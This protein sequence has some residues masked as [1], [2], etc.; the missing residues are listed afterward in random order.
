MQIEHIGSTAVPGLA[1]KPIIDIMVGLENFA[2]A[3]SLVPRVTTLG[4]EYVQKYEA[5]MPLRRYFRRDTNGA[6]SHHLHMVAVGGEF[7]ERHLLFRDYL[8]QH[9]DV[10][11]DYA[12]LKRQLAAREWHDVN[13]YADA[14]TE[15]I[16]SIEERARK[17]R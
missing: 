9:P 16:R 7:W 5:V 1:A 2:L 10:A 14:K 15:F 11:A 12:A 3:D 17:D 8:R 6:R 4:Y 13:D